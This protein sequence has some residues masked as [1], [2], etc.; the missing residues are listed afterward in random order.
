MSYKTGDI[1]ANK[2]RITRDF[3]SAGGGTCQWGFVVNEENDDE[4][5]Y[6][7][8]EFLKP[9]FPTDLASGSEGRKQKRRE[10][11]Y[12]FEE[13]HKAIQ[14]ALSVVGTSGLVVKTEDFF[15]YGDEYGEHYFK[16]CQKVDTSSLSS[17]IHTLDIQS[18]LLV[19]TTASFA[20][21]ILHLRDIIHFDLKPDNILIQKHND[22]HI[23]KIIDFDSSV[24]RDDIIDPS[25]LM[26]DQIYYSPE[27]AKY[28]ISNGETEVPNEKSD[29]FS[30]GLIF[31]QYWTG[32]LP[33]FPHQYNYVYEAILD[34]KKISIPNQQKDIKQESRLKISASLRSQ[35][36]KEIHEL[37]KNMLHDVPEHRPYAQEVHQTLLDIKSRYSPN[38][39]R[40]TIRTKFR[41]SSV[42]VNFWYKCQ[43]CDHEGEFLSLEESTLCNSCGSDEFI[44]KEDQVW[45][46]LKTIKQRNQTIMV[47]VC[48][49]NRGGILVEI[50]NE[51]GFIPGSHLLKNQKQ[52]L[53]DLLYKKLIANI[54]E[55]GECG[56]IILS[57]RQAVAN[58]KKLEEF[59]K[60][61]KGQLVTGKVAGIKPYGV[62][63][64][65]G[66]QT[67]GLLHITNVSNDYIKDLNL[68]FKQGLEVK[69]VIDDINEDKAQIAL[70]TKILENYD[71]EILSNL[72][73]V[74]NEAELRLKA[75]EH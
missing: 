64:D 75:L 68:I 60:L 50:Q 28:I 17:Q 12:R 59:S 27:V 67:T 33:L 61:Q 43:N 24:L 4:T 25:F 40:P 1:I 26:G 70:S 10:E 8:K 21:K 22:A 69:A 18:K 66:K 39:G 32:Q 2:Y 56:D 36:D 53:E 7:I 13:R 3:S 48:G 74:M 20:L 63:I 30:L 73:K 31:C 6:F 9:V 51:R 34:K 72:E 47:N 38:K 54:I 57:H 44:I 52:N 37:I 62:F 71:G 19:M 55:L 16:I 35:E 29:I 41:R 42:G 15:R 14:D 11:C 65:I 23:A 5:E 49:Y 58:F 45:N 46:W